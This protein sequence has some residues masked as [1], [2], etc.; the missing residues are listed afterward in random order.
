MIG[1]DRAINVNKNRPTSGGSSVIARNID[2]PNDV[3]VISLECNCVNSD[4]E[5]LSKKINTKNIKIENNDRKNLGGTVEFKQDIEVK[6]DGDVKPV[7]VFRLIDTNGRGTASV[8]S[9]S[10]GR[11]DIQIDSKSEWFANTYG[12]VGYTLDGVSNVSH[13]IEAMNKNEETTLVS[14]VP[15]GFHIDS[16]FLLNELIYS[17]KKETKKEI[18]VWFVQCSKFHRN[19][20]DCLNSQSDDLLRVSKKFDWIFTVEPLINLEFVKSEVKWHD[21]H[22]ENHRYVEIKENNSRDFDLKSCQD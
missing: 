14:I 3:L 18:E 20:N 7:K 16:E 11:F 6:I 4:K 17:V 22:K 2:A 1:V 13:T 12:I 5:G 15:G 9:N 10:S 8:S 21:G 19:H